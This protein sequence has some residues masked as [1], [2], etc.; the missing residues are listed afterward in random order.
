VA[1]EFVG[2]KGLEPRVDNR[3]ILVEYKGIRIDAFSG[4]AIGTLATEPSIKRVGYSGF[5]SAVLALWRMNRGAHRSGTRARFVV[6][7]PLKWLK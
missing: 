3:K 5:L 1:E 4:T 7:V 6:E 2:I